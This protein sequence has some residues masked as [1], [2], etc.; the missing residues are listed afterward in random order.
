MFNHA[1]CSG[2][3]GTNKSVGYPLCPQVII[4]SPSIFAAFVPAY[5][6]RQAIPIHDLMMEPS[7]HVMT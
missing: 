1:I 5:N 4:K 2:I 7:Y 3:R 6:H